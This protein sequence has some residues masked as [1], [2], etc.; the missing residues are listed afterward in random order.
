[1]IYLDHLTLPTAEEESD[2]FFKQKVTYYD[3]YYPFQIFPNKGLERLDF[4][5]ITILYGGNGSGKST[6]LN[7]LAK[8]IGAEHDSIYNSTDF[9]GTYVQKCKIAYEDDSCTNKVRLSSDGVFDSMLDIRSLNQ[10]IDKKRQTTIDEFL[11]LK[12]I[13][14]YYTD[15]LTPDKKELIHKIRENPMDNIDLLRKKTMANSKT[16]SN[17]TKTNSP[18]NIREKSNGESAF[19]YFVNKIEG[20]GIYLLDEPENSLSPKLQRELVDFLRDSV[21]FYNCQLIIAT[22]S[23]FILSLMGAKIYDLDATPVDLKNWTELENVR[24]YYDF[25][26]SHE[27]EF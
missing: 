4:D 16:L 9:F 5:D 23:P 13:N 6:L 1:M 7:I 12:N 26:K 19:D 27:D 15:N 14:P 8:L 22:H 20:D 24:A 21:R 3:S 17:Y 10:G 11:S 25:F 18:A 2:F